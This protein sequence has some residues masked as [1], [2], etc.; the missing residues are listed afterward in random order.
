MPIKQAEH[1]HNHSWQIFHRFQQVSRLAP[2]T[3]KHPAFSGC[4]ND[5]LSP[6]DAHLDAHG[7]GQ[8]GDLEKILTPF[9]YVAPRSDISAF[10]AKGPLFDSRVYYNS[11]SGKLQ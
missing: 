3:I 1:H 8:C 9:P 7:I 2:Q 4:P 11:P 10:T 6:T 5:W